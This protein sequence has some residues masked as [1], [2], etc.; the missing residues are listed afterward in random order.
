MFCLCTFNI[1]CAV[2]EVDNEGKSSLSSFLV[3]S[4]LLLFLPLY[5]KFNTLITPNKH[6][7][8]NSFKITSYL[9]TTIT[10]V[11][12]FKT[13]SCL[14]ITLHNISNTRRFHTNI[15]RT[16]YLTSIFHMIHIH[17]FKTLSLL[18]SFFTCS[19]FSIYN[20]LFT[21]TL[22]IFPQSTRSILRTSYLLFFLRTS[23][24]NYILPI[25]LKHKFRNFFYF[26]FTSLFF[27]FYCLLMHISYIYPHLSHLLTTS[28]AL[29]SYVF[30][31]FSYYTNKFRIFKY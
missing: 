20:F 10:L 29:S 2:H 13:T 19:L 4:L 26:I 23:F 1:S 28:H 30:K 21:Y 15:F 12:R 14:I 6:V 9:V 18:L 8:T 7:T 27:T 17:T 24:T 16:L 3:K 31:K 25:F 11:F 22:H 5:Y